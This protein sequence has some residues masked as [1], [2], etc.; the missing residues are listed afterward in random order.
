MAARE[1]SR[2]GTRARDLFYL[3]RAWNPLL[4]TTARVY[5]RDE[6]LAGPAGAIAM[7]EVGAAMAAFFSDFLALLGTDHGVVRSRM[8]SSRASVAAFELEF[9]RSVASAIADEAEILDLPD[10]GLGVGVILAAQHQCITDRVLLLEDFEDLAPEIA[11]PALSLSGIMLLLTS[12]RRIIVFSSPWNSSTLDTRGKLPSAPGPSM[13]DDEDDDPR[14]LHEGLSDDDD[15][16]RFLHEGPSMA[17]DEEGRSEDGHVLGIVAGLVEKIDTELHHES[18]FSGIDLGRAIFFVAAILLLESFVIQEEQAR[19]HAFDILV[20]GSSGMVLQAGIDG[21]RDELGDA[22]LHPSLG[23]EHYVLDSILHHPLEERDLEFVLGGELVSR[24]RRTELQVIPDENKLASV[25]REACKYV[26]LEHLSRF[27]DDDNLWLE[28]G[29]HLVQS[30]S[31]GRRHSH[32]FGFSQY[33]ELDFS[34]GFLVRLASGEVVKG[35]P[36][37]LAASFGVDLQEP[38]LMK[39]SSFSH[40]KAPQVGVVNK[41]IQ[42]DFFLDLVG[43]TGCVERSSRDRLVFIYL[44]NLALAAIRLLIRWSSDRL[45]NR[46]FR[47]SMASSKVSIPLAEAMDIRTRDNEDWTVK[48]TRLFLFL[49]GAPTFPSAR[50]IKRPTK[51]LPVPGGP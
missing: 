11:L 49:A 16:P 40:G 34:L 15:D 4:V 39:P 30:S 8:A 33:R 29:Q 10:R 1:R 28:N 51:V 5:L 45:D 24:H 14:F 42:W 7:A 31:P 2:A 17:D 32:N 23:L 47:F 20:L 18:G 25:L 43:G 37:K 6:D 41:D 22:R 44:H 12:E 48:D 38:V 50:T 26:T 21:A 19:L 9:A 35:V 27:F 46:S 3:A 36:G 13:E